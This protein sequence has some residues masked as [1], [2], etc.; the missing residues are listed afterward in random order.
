MNLFRNRL[1]RRR[2]TEAAFG[3]GRARI[4]LTRAFMSHS[5][6]QQARLKSSQAL[7]AWRLAPNRPKNSASAG[8]SQPEY[9]GHVWDGRSVLRQDS[10]AHGQGRRSCYS[11]RTDHRDTNDFEKLSEIRH[12]EGR[13]TGP[14][15]Q[16]QPRTNPELPPTGANNCQPIKQI[17]LQ[18]PGSVAKSKQKMNC[19]SP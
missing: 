4:G 17:R 19:G 5:K 14:H 3:A 16:Q 8:K 18:L 9:T 6:L 10:L 7:Q 15:T 1:T 13:E 12:R 11:T 2:H